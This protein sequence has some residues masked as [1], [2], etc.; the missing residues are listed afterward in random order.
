MEE[1]SAIQTN[2]KYIALSYK[3]KENKCNQNVPKITLKKQLIH[4]F[5][6]NMAI[7]V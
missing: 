7:I 6:K 1:I 5:S 2:Q 4:L 3:D